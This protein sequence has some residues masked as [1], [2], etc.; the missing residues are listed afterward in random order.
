MTSTLFTKSTS[1]WSS[2]SV[3]FLDTRVYLKDGIISTTYIA[4]LQTLTNTINGKAASKSLIPYSQALNLSRIC[5]EDSDFH[6]RA[7]EQKTPPETR[8]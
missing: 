5:S 6:N 7:H 8:L 4:N 1:E 2:S 3:V